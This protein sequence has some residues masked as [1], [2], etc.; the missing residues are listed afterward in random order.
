MKALNIVFDVCLLKIS[1]QNID[2]SNNNQTCL[3]FFNIN[4]FNIKSVIN[5]LLIAFFIFY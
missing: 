2:I 3:L 1:G 4:L 5:S